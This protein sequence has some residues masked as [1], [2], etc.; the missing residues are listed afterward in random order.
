VIIAHSDGNRLVGP[1]VD[2]IRGLDG[3]P[4]RDRS[5][6]VIG[7]VKTK[8]RRKDEPGL[9]IEVG[10]LDPTGVPKQ[11]VRGADK[12]VDVGSNIPKAN[13]ITQ[14][15]EW[16]SNRILKPDFRA[17]IGTTHDG[18]LNERSVILILDSPLYNFKF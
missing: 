17:P 6:K 18:L 14:P 7:C 10:R 2:F 3:I 1:L 4:L 12:I 9:T 16:L 15:R 13:P 11:T 5:G 8:K